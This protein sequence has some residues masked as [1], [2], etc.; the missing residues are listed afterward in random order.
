M[1]GA[2]SAL[3]P[4]RARLEQGPSFV[5]PKPN[6]CRYELR[7]IIWKTEDMDLKDFNLSGGKSSDIYIKG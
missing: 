7:C 5:S 4:L 6:G 1:E 2:P 3:P